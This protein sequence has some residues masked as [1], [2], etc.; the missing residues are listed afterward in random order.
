MGFVVCI[1]EF[2]ESARCFFPNIQH[3][4]SRL[5][6]VSPARS[7]TLW[8]RLGIQA[9]GVKFHMYPTNLLQI[10]MMIQYGP[11]L[12]DTY[13]IWIILVTVYQIWITYDSHLPGL[14]N[15]QK[16]MEHHLAIG[17][18]TISTGPLSSSQSVTVITRPGN[19]MNKGVF[20]W[21]DPWSTKQI[22]A[23]LHHGSYNGIGLCEF[24]LGSMVFTLKLNEEWMTTWLGLWKSS[25]CSDLAGF[26][27]TQSGIP[28]IWAL[29]L[30]S[31]DL[32]LSKATSCNKLQHLY[33]WLETIYI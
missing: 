19:P 20:C 30:L 7:A 18:S 21:W 2:V 24:F 9:A 6:R 5:G 32:Q 13:E 28:M 4:V 3:A 33:I 14:V 29:K 1:A 23:P 15:I 25:R 12:L 10:G 17:K 27:R 22:A 8:V 26:G 31:T 16:T 11:N